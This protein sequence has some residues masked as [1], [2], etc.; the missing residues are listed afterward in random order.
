MSIIL[1]ALLLG[2][3]TA[4]WVTDLSPMLVDPSC[5]TDDVRVGLA[6]FHRFDRTP[7]LV[8][9]PL[10]E[11]LYLMYMP[12]VRLLYRAVV[13]IAGLPVAT[14]IVQAIALAMIAF[15]GLI[16]IR[17]RRAGLAAGVLL[18]FL[19]MHEAYVINRIAGG[20][21]RA[22]I[23]PFMLLWFAGAVTK[24]ERLRAIVALLASIAQANAAMIVLLAEGLLL[25]LDLG[26]SIWRK[27]KTW[28]FSFQDPVIARGV[29]LTVLGVLC[30]ALASIYSATVNPKLGSF[31]SY[32]AALKNPAFIRGNYWENELP[33]P[34]PVEEFSRAV[35]SPLK[36]QYKPGANFLSKAWESTGKSGPLAVLAMLL[37]LAFAYSRRIALIPLALLAASAACYA[38]ARAMAFRL[39]SPE[40]YY[41]FGGPM[42]AIALIV[43]AIG[44]TH[45]LRK[46]K[47]RAVI[48]NYAAVAFIALVWMSSG[49]TGVADGS[50]ACVISEKPN[51]ALYRYLETLPPE[52]RILAH[53]HDADD[54]PW[55]AGRA[56]TGGFEMCM[57]WFVDAHERCVT[58]MTNALH[59]YYA[60]DRRALLDYLSSD[61]ITHILIHK[62]RLG[63]QF[64]VKSGV[65]EPIQTVLKKW[66]AGKTSAAFVLN[67]LPADAVIFRHGP[68]ELIDIAKLKSGWGM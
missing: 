28:K 14:K 2:A 54:I 66:L 67:A 12:A 58:R 7:S 53:P 25:L 49:R 13:P 24:N 6:A 18:I 8:E 44:C 10:A 1:L 62:E 42:T 27:R 29:R 9:D 56:T 65:A 11:D 47:V 30:V 45:I 57:V 43:I 15:A 55:W 59:G 22:F 48:Q 38:A 26:I 37:V 16:L 5:Q 41:A 32:E 20:L 60:V 40:R 63:P 21:G 51:L 61:R 4:K 31:I 39:Y 19:A 35:S 33:F 17:S 36:E 68:F 52:I 23:F 50:A 3:Y 64:A 34:N 46:K